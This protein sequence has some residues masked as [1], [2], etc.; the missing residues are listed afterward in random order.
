MS[1]SHIARLQLEIDTVKRE[2]EQLIR[3]KEKE[4]REKE[5]L[6]REKEQL[7]R[8][9]EQL[10][11]DNQKT[12]L[13][14][15]LRDCHNYLYKNF[16]VAD[17]SAC[18]TGFLEV[19][20][21]FY[22]KWLRPWAKFADSLRQQQLEIIREAFEGERIF[23][24]EGTTRDLATMMPDQPAGNEIAVSHFERAAVE[25][26]V[27]TIL[28][29]LE[30]QEAVCARYEY[31]KLRFDYISRDVMG[32]G[33]EVTGENKW[34]ELPESQQKSKPRR[35]Y[36]DG[37]GIRTRSDGDE[38]VAF[39]YD[40]QAAHKIAAKYVKAAI[41]KETLFMEV[42]EQTNSIES[43]TD[44]EPEQFQ[45]EAQ[46]AMALTQVFDYMVNYGVAYGYVAAGE[47]LLLLHMDRSEPQTLFCHPC[48]PNEDVGE[49]SVEDWA[50]KM[51]YTAVAQLV[52][53]SLLSLQYDPLQG[54]LLEAALERAGAA[55]KKW[56]E[57]YEHPAHLSS[58]EDTES[59]V[60]ASSS[61]RQG[62]DQ[63]FT[64]DVAAPHRVV[65]LRS[66]SWK[67]PPLPSRNDESKEEDGPEGSL[68][69]P[70]T[71]LGKRQDGPSHST[72]EEDETRQS[73][74]T[75]HYCSQ[76]CMLGLKKGWD[77]DDGCPNV[78]LHRIQGDGGLRHPI[79][80][81]KFTRLVGERLREDPYRD[82][83]ALDG[84]GK[85]GSVG[86]LFRLELRPYGYTFV[87][88]GTILGGLKYLE[89]ECRVYMR[90]DTLQG[91]A[92]P[93]NF[94]LVHLDK[95]YILPGALW[96]IHMMLMSWGGERAVDAD[97]EPE[98]IRAQQRIS[99][100]D[101]WSHGV[102]HDDVRDNNLLWNV[103]RRR[104]MV[105]DFDRAIF[106]P[107]PSHRQLSKTKT[108]TK[109]KRTSRVK[110]AGASSLKHMQSA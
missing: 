48:V 64:P 53:F 58:A 97:V 69:R 39:V 101:V 91:W 90:L 6:T 49:V 40:F 68:P 19:N 54:I 105:I 37:A 25:T 2:K 74:P 14:E 84:K 96:V 79:T 8:E 5:Q 46:I 15:Y 27:S 9:K 36:P 16:S 81:E 61:S 21:K 95:G 10:I 26:P 23:Y 4:R 87:A 78:S 71:R 47:S 30:R 98:E 33:N 102:D 44:D 92:V 109:T 65:P 7:I 38:S 1:N 3:E 93:V 80:A 110:C 11:R 94:G 31:S 42:V 104:V 70:R 45:A 22:P 55:L 72:C 52:S 12:T 43:T 20:G 77:L 103:E 17:N 76:A 28:R 50:D 107:A 60:A 18:S 32:L 86:V 59:S 41:A 73:A 67:D 88:K 62:S 108:K 75:S 89:H 66:T 29:H 83:S 24:C 51:M 99:L 34:A 13:H 57:P 56:P 35:T 63:D 106:L 85:M 100:S 82:C